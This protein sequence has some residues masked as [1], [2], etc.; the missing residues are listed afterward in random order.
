MKEVFYK[1]ICSKCNKEAPWVENKQRYGRNFGKSYMCYFC[2]PCGT[3]VGC[4]NNTRKPL[5]TMA[6]EYTMK[7]RRNAHALFDKLWKDGEMSRGQ[8]YK[9]LSEHFG[10]EMHIGESNS[11][12]CKEIIN[13]LSGDNQ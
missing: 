11:E 9:I 2:R 4:H 12:V 1:V 13:Y 7:L 10:R 8:A 5:G 3:Y 6:D